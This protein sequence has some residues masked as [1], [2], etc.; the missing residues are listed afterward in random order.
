MDSSLKT[1]LQGGAATTFRAVHLAY[2]GFDL[3]L[4]DQGF[5]TLGGHVYA[6]EDATYGVLSTVG[7]ISDGDGSEAARLTL[8][9][10]V[11]TLS[12]VEALWDPAA[13]GSPV[14]LYWG[15]VDSETGALIGAAETPFVGV[16]D[17]V[18]LMTGPEGWSLEIDCASGQDLA[19]EAYEGQTLS[20]GFHQS[21]WPGE[22]GLEYANGVQGKVYWGLDEPR[23]SIV[24]GG[25]ATARLNVSG[26][27]VAGPFG[28]LTGA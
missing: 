24:S 26:L 21:I 17:T 20:D 1:A 22:R 28:L 23:G 25:A 4:T 19:L 6:A 27:L 10:L 9:L 2:P 7:E 16:V 11:P 13:Q 8:T 5:V 12:A 15:A 3:R 14:T 18:R